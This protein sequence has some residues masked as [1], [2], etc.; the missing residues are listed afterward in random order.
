M[1]LN[2]PKEALKIA[3][4]NSWLRCR[5][6]PSLARG[7]SLGGAWHFP[8]WRMALPLLAH[9]SSLDGAWHLP[10]WRMANLG[11]K[12]VSVSR[13]LSPLHSQPDVRVARFVLSSSIANAVK[14]WIAK[15]PYSFY[16]YIFCHD[17]DKSVWKMT[18][19]RI[20]LFLL[21]CSLFSISCS[22]LCAW[23]A[24]LVFGDTVTPERRLSLFEVDLLGS[25]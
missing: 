22:L 21:I 7:T 9:G 5:W 24:C 25:C 6:P 12:T 23:D 10:W 16:V 1:R 15:I 17:D 4:W 3:C 11:L 8:R 20:Y 2:D 13:K 18:A 14:I 19:G